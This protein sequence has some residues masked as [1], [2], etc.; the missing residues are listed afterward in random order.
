MKLPDG[1]KTSPRLL[2]HQFETEPL[3]FMDAMG[4][5]Y[6]DIFTIMADSVPLVIVSNPEGIKQIFTNA[7]E[8]TASVDVC[9]EPF[10]TRQAVVT[11]K[12][13]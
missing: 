3:G 10:V 4:E 9:F 7:K 2:S 12:I 5:H 8:I 13:N 6:G 1:P 11:S